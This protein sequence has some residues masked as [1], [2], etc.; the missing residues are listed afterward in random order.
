[1]N[2][3]C[4]PTFWTKTIVYRSMRLQV[5]MLLVL[6]FPP[7]IF[8]LLLA[9]MPFSSNYRGAIYLGYVLGEVQNK[10][11]KEKLPLQRDV[12]LGKM[13]LRYCVLFRPK[14]LVL[15]FSVDIA[16][17]PLCCRWCSPTPICSFMLWRTLTLLMALQFFRLQ[18]IRTCVG[19]EHGPVISNDLM[20]L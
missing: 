7:V 9:S 11:Y 6:K 4:H 15:L 3:T 17:S 10:L 16:V 12:F 18:S 8:S 19:C 14:H 5:L 2:K 13:Y 1:M 20:W